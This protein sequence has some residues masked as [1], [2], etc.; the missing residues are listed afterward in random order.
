[1]TRFSRKELEAMLEAIGRV[2]A[3]EY[4]GETDLETFRSAQHKLQARLW[5]KK[6]KA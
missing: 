5:N 1:M 2:L 4:D 3:D 6:E